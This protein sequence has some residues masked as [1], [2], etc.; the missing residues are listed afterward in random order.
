[1]IVNALGGKPLPVYGDGRQVRDWLFVED[2]C[3]AIEKILAADVVGRTFNVGG[4]AEHEN[5]Y[6]VEQLCALVDDALR[7]CVAARALSRLPRFAR[8][9]LP[10]AGYARPRPSRARPSV[11]DR[12]DRDRDAARIRAP[13]DAAHRLGANGRLVSRARELVAGSDGRELPALDRAPIWGG[14]TRAT[15]ASVVN[16]FTGLLPEPPPPFRYD[17]PE[18]TPRTRIR[19]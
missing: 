10:R 8:R 6:I 14:V 18:T 2:H 3:I 4:R 13:R 7:R 11:C 17:F 9:E 5:I 12:S 15:E 1:M 16:E 19:C